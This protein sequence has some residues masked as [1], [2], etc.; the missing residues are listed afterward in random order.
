MKS[1]SI[2]DLHKRGVPWWGQ[3]WI[4]ENSI[5]CWRIGQAVFRIER[6]PGEWRLMSE[7]DPGFPDNETAVDVPFSGPC[8]TSRTNVI[9]R[10]GTNRAAN[11]V[12]LMPL[13][14]DRNVVVQ[15][16]SP[17]YCLP[18]QNLTMYVSSPLWIAVST[19]MPSLVMMDRPI[20]RPSDTWFG[21]P[22]A[23]GELCYSTTS[24]GRIGLDDVVK[25]P[26][27]A[28]IV[29]LIRNHT[30]QP[31]LMR[32]MK[33]PVLHL[34]L[35][36]SEDG[37]LWTQP[38]TVDVNESAEGAEIGFKQ[39]PPAE[40]KNAALITEPR[41]KAVDNTLTQALSRLIK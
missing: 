31:V 26:H 19:G 35:Y 30:S 5:G 3:Y 4:E 18:G 20:M 32:T 13:L 9:A 36:E 8:E 25:R 27:R 21:P 10:F 17:L 28:V 7:A 29:V 1:D 23:Q 11:T 33:L 14:P 16:E 40:A 39:R 15:S 34:S 2:K 41:M 6:L 38:V 12:R 22:T 37:N 24:S